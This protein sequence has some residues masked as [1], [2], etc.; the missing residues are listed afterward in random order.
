MDEHHGR[1]VWREE[2]VTLLWTRAEIVRN[3]RVGNASL[4]R[5]FIVADYVVR[6]VLQ[7]LC[8]LMQVLEV[9]RIV[10]V[11]VNVTVRRRLE[12][13]LLVL[14]L[15]VHRSPMELWTLG[16]LLNEAAVRLTLAFR[17][18]LRMCVVMML[19]VV[20]VA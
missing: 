5:R 18:R 20:N 17:E 3:V 2:N 4:V 19:K 7:R 11:H 6:G 15:V 10:L 1:L 9:I 14:Q 12:E 13:L 8:D 16:H